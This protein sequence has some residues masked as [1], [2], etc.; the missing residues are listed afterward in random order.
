MTL[1]LTVLEAG[2]PN[3]RVLAGLVSCEG[4]LLLPRWYL[5]LGSSVE[6]KHCLHVAQIRRT[7]KGQIPPGNFFQDGVNPFVKTEPYLSSHRAFGIQLATHEFWRRNI[8][9]T[10]VIFH[11]SPPTTTTTTKDSPSGVSGPA[12]HPW[13]SSHTRTETR[14][15]PSLA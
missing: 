6:R 15:S 12:K 8:Q 7:A 10:A 4:C 1:F 3:F 5:E 13:A 2:K 11:L 14:N 9:S